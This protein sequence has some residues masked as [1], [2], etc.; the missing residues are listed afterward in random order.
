MY[1]TLSVIIPAYNC[2]STI[3]KCIDS[4]RKQ[5]YDDLE[6]II[7]DDGSDDNTYEI[8]TY[9]STFD[10]RIKVFTKENGGQASARNFGLKF[11]S[12]KY[13]TFVDDDDYIDLNMYE[14]LISNMVNNNVK[15]SGCATIAEDDSGNRI[16]N[17]VFGD[18][19]IKDGDEIIHNI[20]YRNKACWGT[21]WNKVFDARLKKYLL[22]P[23][24]SEL[25][26]YYVILKLMYF[27]KQ[28]YY[29]E[30]QL[31]H[32]IQ[33]NTSQSHRGFHKNRLTEL[34]VIDDIISFYSV[35]NCSYKLLKDCHFFKF[36]SV[37]SI[38]ILIS[39]SDIN[40]CRLKI[41]G[42]LSNIY[43]KEFKYSFPQK[44]E[45]IQTLKDAIHAFFVVIK[46]L[47][48]RRL[49]CD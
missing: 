1:G 47:F 32:W 6:I 20:L 10:N 46:V 42:E 29:D 23:E 9:L 40:I 19:G 2:E 24:G 17:T 39:K 44:Y 43:F 16:G 11:V 8:C 13:I 25:E 48:K 45:T 3:L 38:M 34:N 28:V 15:I 18:S 41:M 35:N 4:I 14:I 27:I 22:F 5:T 26:D 30:R 12:G 37:S 49:G 31:Y 36:I 7:V 33:R 21:V